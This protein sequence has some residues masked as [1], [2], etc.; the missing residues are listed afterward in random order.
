[1]INAVTVNANCEVAMFTTS[2][3]GSFIT[4]S[5]EGVPNANKL[6]GYTITRRAK[7]DTAKMYNVSEKF[8]VTNTHK[9]FHSVD[10]VINNRCDNQDLYN[11]IWF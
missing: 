11:R 2:G 5:N 4:L 6:I 10:Y 3:C 9:A 8:I 7:E 1:M